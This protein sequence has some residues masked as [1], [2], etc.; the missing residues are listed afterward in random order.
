MAKIRLPI[1][2]F[3]SMFSVFGHF[4]EFREGLPLD[5]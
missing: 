5:G 1:L 2:H 4:G 3:S